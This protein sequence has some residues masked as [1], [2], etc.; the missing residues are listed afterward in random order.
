LVNFDGSLNTSFA[1]ASDSTIVLGMGDGFHLGPLMSL[2]IVAHEYTHL[3]TEFNGHGGLVY[4]AES[5]ALNESFSDIFGTCVEFKNNPEPNWTVGEKVT[6]VPPFYTRSM[7]NPK[8]GGPPQPDTYQG[9][10]WFDVTNTAMDNGGVHINSGV[11]NK[12]FY[13]L[14]QGGTGTN[15]KG[16]TYNVTGIGIA[17]AQQIAYRNLVTYILPA[18]QY[19]DAYIGSLQATK[20]LY[21]SDTTKP[22]YKAVRE[23]WY[24]VGIGTK[25]ATT[26]VNEIVVTNGDLKLYPNPATGRVTISSSLNQTLDAQIINVVGVPVMNITVSKG[27][28]PVDI[29]ALA[30]GMYMI[31]YNTSTKGYVQKLSVL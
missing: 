4:Q 10:H 29:S 20:D 6:L 21:G 15:D 24:A 17:K 8:S 23:A 26:A 7:S 2:D 31:R 13:L 22:E 14:A 25:P 30:K 3:V 18:S 27:L 1:V 9:Q 28:N 12:W 5:G 19:I 16:D 11:Q